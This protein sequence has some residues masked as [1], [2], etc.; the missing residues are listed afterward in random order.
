MTRV[1]TAI[2][3]L[4]AC[5]AV[6]LIGAGA[7]SA[8]DT[9]V[10]F[11]KKVAMTGTAKNGKK[12]TGTYTINRFEKRG[13]AVYAVGTL[14]GTLKGRH[15]K[16]SN[17]AIPVTVGGAQGA[18]AAR[19]CTVLDLTLGPLDLRLLGLRVQLNQV[20]LVVTANDQEG[21]LGQLLCALAGPL[22][23]GGLLGQ[24]QG[25]LAQLAAVLNAILALGG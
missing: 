9:S 20:H 8:Q 24:L 23:T 12:F 5:C 13:N 6:S 4:M 11:S 18:Q 19:I 3:A 16:R 25:L 7:A 1:R 21:I 2:V 14:S 15:V 17:V 10:P 22:N